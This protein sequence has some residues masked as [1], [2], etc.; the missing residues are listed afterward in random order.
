MAIEIRA[1]DSGEVGDYLRAAMRGFHV[2]KVSDEFVALRREQ[3]VPGR[4]WVALDGTEIVATLR[5]AP[6]G[7]TMPG[8]ATMPTAG[9]T[10]VAVAATHRRHGLMARLLTAELHAARE[11]GEPIASLIAAEWPIYGRFGFGPAVDYTEYELDADATWTNPGDGTIE[12][13]DP[14]TLLIHAPA[15]Y[16]H[17][18][19]T[20]VGEIS[21]IPTWWSTITHAVELEPWKG[22]QV[23]CRD[24]AGEVTGYAIYSIEEHWAHRKPDCSLKIDELVATNLTTEA[25]L[26]RYLCE[27]DWVTRVTAES[28]RAHEPMHHWVTD[29]RA[30][31][32]TERTDMVWARTLDTPAALTGR[33]YAGAG[34]VVFDVDDPMKLA[35]GRFRLDTNGSTAT[36]TPTTDAP[37]MSLSMFALGAIL[38]GGTSLVDL[39]HGGLVTEHQ[40]GSV[41]RADRLFRWPVTP[42]SM[43]W[44]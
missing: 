21:R 3:F 10:N 40:S 8:G 18:R 13:V 31:T 11:R 35:G 25:R 38:Y 29:G 15:V 43:T 44:F 42:W 39:H 1:I 17:H 4:Y 26:W 19:S 23:L 2:N 37:D 9:V 30:L 16:E 36:C 22:F 27:V 12:L 34:T 20:S 14:A 24:G 41:L 7:T 33:A 6:L 28:R 5:S 32:L